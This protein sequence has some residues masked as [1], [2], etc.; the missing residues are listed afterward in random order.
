MVTA[1]LE[2]TIW[3][4]GCK[5]TVYSKSH[6][7]EWYWYGL[8]L[9]GQSADCGSSKTPERHSV[10][11]IEH[12]MISSV[13][14]QFPKASQSKS[15]RL[16][17]GQPVITRSQI[18]WAPWT[19]IFG[20]LQWT[21]WCQKNIISFWFASGQQVLVFRLMPW[22]LS[23]SVP[24]IQAS[25]GSIWGLLYIMVP[26]LPVRTPSARPYAGFRGCGFGPNVYLSRESIIY[27]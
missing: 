10:F 11:E 14:V 19:F 3:S 12:S 27:V 15:F 6:T 17:D 16:Q 8:S 13:Q 9:V 7:S 1:A 4:H 26:W 23:S 24:C 25:P 2:Y 20:W 22:F 5:Y 18:P 21:Y